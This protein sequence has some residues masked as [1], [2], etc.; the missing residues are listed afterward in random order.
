MRAQ[1]ATSPAFR[2]V[3]SSTPV[4]TR[5]L[6]SAVKNQPAALRRPMDSFEAA[7]SRAR[8][9]LTLVSASTPKPASTTGQGLLNPKEIPAADWTC[10][11]HLNADNNL[12][13][14]GKDD[15]NEME[16]VGSLQG[17]LNMIALVDGGSLKDGDGWNTGARLMYV[18]KDPSNTSK[19]V[20][21]EIAVDPK[22]DLGKLMAAGKG[23][24]DTGSPQVLR[25]ALDYVQ[26]NVESKH[27]MVDL[28]DHG[29]GWRGVSYD[30]KPSSSLDMNELK[31]ALTGL[32]KKVDILAADACL[33]AT[34]EVA[35]TA[36][37]AGADWLVGS[38]ELEPGTGW[39]YTDL[40]TRASK[41]FE[42]G[43]A[44][45]PEQMAKLIQDSY[46]VGPKD[47]VTMSTTNLSKLDALNAKLDGFSN[48]LL[49]AGGLQNKAL[50]ATYEQTLRFDD[51]NQMDLGDFA[52]R[53]SKETRD[54][55][56]KAAADQLL[57]ALAQ[58]T[59]EKGVKGGDSR[60][61]A[62]T[63]LSIYAPQ[64]SVE[65]EYQQAGSSWLASRWNDVIATYDNARV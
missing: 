32:P 30:D 37:A 49:K 15:L 28:W 59:T 18:T 6:P 47:N 27:F 65:R 61:A 17:K 35:D 63:G 14:F 16:A 12:E 42:G 62:A 58:T 64:G 51:K 60:Y 48:A 13:S 4:T 1:N 43:K 24:L 2:P 8:S 26:R 50:R 23:E 9:A 56:L 11:V 53:V 54:P 38:E 20:S 34:V 19:I 57:A 25:A 10:F 52:R 55:G 41:L 44:V 21:R 5:A 33:M 29:N 45:S 39:N 3:S 22:S 40:L 7:P 46:I 36:K 31:Q